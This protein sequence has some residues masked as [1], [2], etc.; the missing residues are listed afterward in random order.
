M[1]GVILI[2]EMKL[3]Q[4][5][6]FDSST[7]QVLGFKD[8]GEDNL[9]AFG[10][11][12]KESVQEAE[13]KLPVDPKAPQKRKRRE[14]AKEKQ[15]TKRDKN[16]GDH[17]LV[18][19]FQPFRGKWVQAIACF[20]TRGNASDDELTKIIL[21]AVVLLERSGLLVDAVVTDGATWNRS[22]WTKFG[23]TK[24]NPSAEHPT[25]S[26]RKLWF[27]SD[28]PHLVK[29]MRNCMV[30]KKIIMVNIK[31][32]VQTMKI[33]KLTY[34]F[35]ILKVSETYNFFSDSLWRCEAASLASST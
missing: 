15:Q 2:D 3:T 24:D 27:I 9:E 29:C 10:E 34:L 18:V 4:G 5:V 19:S 28:F 16:L 22:M 12:I 1:A 23:V 6:Y 33:I 20:L 32:K 7:L 13:E 21:E 30:E 35:Q 11:D 31:T 25:D 17:A 14:K 26:N 8:L